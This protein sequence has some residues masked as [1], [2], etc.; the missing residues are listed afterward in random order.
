MRVRFHL[1]FVSVKSSWTRAHE[2]NL[3]NRMPRSATY[4]HRHECEKPEAG[5][6]G[7]TK[8][9]DELNGVLIVKWR[10]CRMFAFT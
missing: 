9:C 10:D 1:G 3:H 4:T 5:R 8:I 7:G 6:E 2:T